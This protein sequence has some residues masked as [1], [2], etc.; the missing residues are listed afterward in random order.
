MTAACSSGVSL[1]IPQSSSGPRVAKIFP[2]TRKSGCP[3]CA[4]SDASGRLRAKLRN[5]AAVMLTPPDQARTRVFEP[6]GLRRPNPVFAAN[7]KDAERGQILGEFCQADESNTRKRPVLPCAVG[8]QLARKQN[9][10]RRWDTRSIL[11]GYKC[12]RPLLPRLTGNPHGDTSTK[13]AKLLEQVPHPNHR[14]PN[15]Q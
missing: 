14:L 11:G 1:T 5:S 15:R 8:K 7:D 12:Q 2:R 13:R 4:D 3:I 6:A 9:G 10:C